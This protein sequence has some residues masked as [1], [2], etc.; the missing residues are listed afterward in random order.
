GFDLANQFL[1][2]CYDYAND[3]YPYFIYSSEKFPTEEEQI[4]FIR[5]YLDQ[6]VE[7][8]V[9]PS[10]SVEDEIKV[11]LQEIDIFSM[12]VNL[13]WALWSWKMT[14]LSSKDFGYEVSLTKSQ[15]LQFLI[16]KTP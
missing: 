9:I 10:T 3:E 13:L 4:S 16:L 2:W 1:E 5:A 6:L 8:G 15:K 11:I 14:F 12:A 7:E